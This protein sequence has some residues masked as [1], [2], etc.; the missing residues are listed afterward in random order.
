M[1]SF[2]CLQKGTCDSVVIE[3]CSTLAGGYSKLICN[4]SASLLGNVTSVFRV[5]QSG[6]GA[7]RAM[8]SICPKPCAAASSDCGLSLAKVQQFSAGNQKEGAPHR[9]SRERVALRSACFCC[10]ASC[11]KSRPAT[12]AGKTSCSST[13]T[14]SSRLRW[15]WKADAVLNTTSDLI[16]RLTSRK[17]PAF[18]LTIWFQLSFLSFQDSLVL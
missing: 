1:R 4:R 9:A 17:R 18:C 11:S 10:T 3:C 6:K 15:T 8:I 5:M 13:R 14:I 12:L 16:G 7:S 2:W